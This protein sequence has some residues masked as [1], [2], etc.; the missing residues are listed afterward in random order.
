MQQGELQEGAF[1]NAFSK[2][3]K[4][5][6]GKI[7]KK[8]LLNFLIYAA[9]KRRVYSD[10]DIERMLD[11]KRSK[12]VKT[13]KEPKYDVVN[14]CFEELTKGLAMTTQAHFNFVP[15][16]EDVITEIAREKRCDPSKIP[17]MKQG[18]E[19]QFRE[20]FPQL[21]MKM[22]QTRHKLIKE[23]ED[24][25]FQ[26]KRVVGDGGPSEGGI[27]KFINPLPHILKESESR[28]ETKPRTILEYRETCP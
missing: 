10:L 20:L 4:N 22:R 6:D 1:S 21:F 28:R 2:L 17:S 27:I 26:Q 25:P 5:G 11:V 16:E 8:E 18:E 23:Q 19:K 24:L 12:R 15:S 9:R 3:D 7:S 14:K 13:V